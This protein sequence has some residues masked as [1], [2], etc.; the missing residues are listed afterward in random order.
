MKALPHRIS[1]MDAAVL[2]CALEDQLMREAHL[3]S[4][5]SLGN[6]RRLTEIRNR[7]VLAHGYQSISHQESA[8][9]EKRA[10]HI[11]NSYWRLTYPDQNLEQR[12]EQLRFLKNL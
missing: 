10:K 1:L 2:L 11:L 5:E 9:L 7:S 4:A 6:L 8:E 12:I 3:H